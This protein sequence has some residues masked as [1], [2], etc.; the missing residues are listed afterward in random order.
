MHF[1][2]TIRDLFWLVGVIMALTVVVAI[3]AVCLFHNVDWRDFIG[4]EL[5][6]NLIPS[7]ALLGNHRRRGGF[8]NWAS[9]RLG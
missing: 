4:G 2:F 3:V 8:E 5:F 1:C 6:G 9:D 7:N